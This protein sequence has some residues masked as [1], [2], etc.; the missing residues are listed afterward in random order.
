MTEPHPPRPPHVAPSAEG[1]FSVVLTLDGK[2]R[3]DVDPMREEIPGFSIDEAP[4]LG[5]GAG[6]SPTRVLAAALASC[7]G[8]SLLFCLRKARV[9]VRGLRVEATGTYVRNDAGRLRIGSL[10]VRLH[11]TLGDTDPA[12]MGRCLEIFEDYCIISQ[13]L[14][15]GVPVDVK[16]GLAE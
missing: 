15:A 6:P 3:F 12:R 2:Y 11:P 7:L 5:D 16:L 4:P 9:D 8:S 13:S 10:S 14:R 1:G